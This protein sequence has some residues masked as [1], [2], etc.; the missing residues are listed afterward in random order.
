MAKTIPAAY[1]QLRL[2]LNEVD[3]IRSGPLY[4]GGRAVVFPYLEMG[5]ISGEWKGLTPAQPAGR[6]TFR[7]RIHASLGQGLDRAIEELL[8]LPER[9]HNK[10][11]YGNNK[12]DDTVNSIDSLSYTEVEGKVGDT[13][14][15]SYQFEFSVMIYAGQSS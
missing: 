4:P 14:T 1:A 8:P 5:P 11:M 15:L 2:R 7:F 3:G 10:L 12:L 9:V 6:H 13:V